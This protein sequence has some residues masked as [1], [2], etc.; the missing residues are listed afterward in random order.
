ML[1]N[2]C[3]PALL[4]ALLAWPCHAD[5]IE[6]FPGQSFELAAENLSAGDTLIVHAGEYTHTNRIAITVQG[7]AQNPVVI[8]GADG[9]ARP[10]IRLTAGGHNTIDISGAT[11]LTIRGLEITAPG[12]GGADGI[13][14]NGN[15]SYITIE[16][17]VIHDVSVG[18]NLRSSMHHIF[19]RR[20]EIYATNDTGEGLY[21]GCHTGSCVVSGL[22]LR[23]QLHTRHEE[24]PAG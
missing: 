12:I 24:F 11:Y 17:N 2:R 14:L 7:T 18:V 19:V 4:L 8:R 5:I 20:N 21:V 1:L 3:I 10:V 15:P 9:E 22:D 16:D 13:N 23:T 6:I